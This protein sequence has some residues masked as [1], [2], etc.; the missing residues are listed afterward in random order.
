VIGFRCGLFLVAVV[1]LAGCFTKQA[2]KNTGPLVINVLDKALYDDCHIPGSVRVDFDKVERYVSDY[3]KDHPIVV[4]CSNFA[5]MTSHFVVN[6]LIEKGYTQARIYA[7]GMADWYQAGYPVE[8]PAQQPY[9]HK[10]ME[11]EDKE[12]DR[13]P[14]INTQELAELLKIV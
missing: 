14:T 13:L 12:A 2:T 10:K 5:C 6:K 3:K 1:L 7:G 4:Y 8:G 11:L 9:L